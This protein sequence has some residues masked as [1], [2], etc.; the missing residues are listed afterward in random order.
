MTVGSVPSTSP[1][2]SP[3]TDMARRAGAAVRDFRVR[4]QFA[5]GDL[6]CSIIDWE[7]APLPGTLT[8]AEILHVRNGTIV[9]GELIYDAEDLR[10]ATAQP[11]PGDPTDVVAL[12]ERCYRDTGA[13][14]AAITPAGFAAA[15]PCTGWT[16]RQVGSHLVDGLILLARIAEGETV[17]PAEFDAH[18]RA[19][20]DHLGADPAAAFHA[21]AQRSTAVFK[22][23]ETLTRSY[24]FPSGPTPGA[25]LARISL[26][27]SLV[28]GWDLAHGAGLPYPADR[29]VVD[30]VHA[31]ATQSIGDPQRQAGMFA[32]PVPVDSD[33]DPLTALLAYL[34]RRR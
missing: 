12:L 33:A 2:Q 31:F 19:G 3:A 29:T 24:P 25:V 9:R 26:L 27:E 5:E 10:K 6:V 32:A 14:L 17:S 7:M 30:A 21:A 4:H 16:V 28:H 22:L 11:D 13:V 8:A 23:P 1:N 20:A 34:G 15:S 18:A